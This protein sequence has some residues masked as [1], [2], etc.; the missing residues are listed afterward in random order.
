MAINVSP[1]KGYDEVNDEVSKIKSRKL[2]YTI[3]EI[4]QVDPVELRVEISGGVD[5]SSDLRVTPSEEDLNKTFE[6][7][8]KNLGETNASFV[9][10]NF[11]YYTEKKNYREM[12][13]LVSFI[14]ENA[15]LRKKIAMASNTSV[16]RNSLEMP[17]YI[18]THE[19]NEFT[20]SRLKQECLSIQ[21]K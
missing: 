16:L 2:T 6:E 13:M 19:S 15:N 12:M 5:C 14:P 9:V 3:F 11:G 18:E 7:C 21:R 4:S 17:V 20:F 10:Y 1:I 8:K